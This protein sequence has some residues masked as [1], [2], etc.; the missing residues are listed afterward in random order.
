MNGETNMVA[1]VCARYR[2]K[3]SVSNRLIMNAV[4]KVGGCC[5]VCIFCRRT[6]VRLAQRV[7]GIVKA[8]VL[9]HHRQTLKQE[10]VAPSQNVEKN[11]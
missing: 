5:V 11:P 1:I 6:A 8:A 10:Q 7:K 2:Q 3:S 4:M 9:M